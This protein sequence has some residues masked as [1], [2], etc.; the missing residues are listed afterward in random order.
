MSLPAFSQHLRGTRR[1]QTKHTRRAVPRV[2]QD[3]PFA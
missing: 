1:R 3:E 2:E